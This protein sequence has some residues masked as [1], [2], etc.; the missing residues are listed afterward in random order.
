[1]YVWWIMDKKNSDSK[2]GL[3]HIAAF[4][5]IGLI[6]GVFASL[7]TTVADK[8]EAK[9]QMSA[10]SKYVKQQCVRY[11]EL[12]DEY[13][14]RNLMEVSDKAFAISRTLDFSSA[15]LKNDIGALAETNR[16]NGIFVTA[17]DETSANVIVA[18]YSDGDENESS[19]KSILE[20]YGSVAGDFS[21]SYS[22]RVKKDGY[23][24]DCGI[25]SRS[26]GKGVVL[27]YRRNR[28][29]EVEDERFSVKTLLSGFV[30]STDGVVV[31][32]DGYNVLAANIDGVVG[33]LA[34]DCPVI[35]ELR[36]S[37]SHNELVLVEDDGVY[38]GIKS[39]TKDLFVYTYM[40]NADVFV[41]RSMILPYL[42][43]FY[44]LAVSVIITVRAMTI[45]KKR[46]EQERKD[47]AYRI[48][49]EKLAAEAIRA[50]EAKTDFLR[51]MSH[52]IRT[53]INGI[54]GMVKIGEYYYDDPE[55]QRECR[56]KIWD[57]SGYLLDLVNDI[58][59]MNK[60]TTTEP[61][62]N[63]EYF[64]MSELLND[65]DVFTGVQ[66]KEAGI[67][68]IVEPRA[69]VHDYVYGGKVQ[70][71]RILINLA[72]NAIKY[73][74][75]NG[76]VVVS[77]KETGYKNGIV[78]FEC[79]CADTGIGMDEEFLQKMYEPF[80][81]E[82][83]T[84]GAT[85][86]GVGLG[87]SIVKKLIDRA[88]WSI[89]AESKKGEGTTFTVN[90]SLKA[91]ETREKA[92]PTPVKDEKDRLKGLN[93]LVAED[94]ELNFEIV[95]FVLDVAGAKI[96]SAKDG[97]EAVNIFKE[98]EEGSIDAILMDVM[99][100]VTDGLT[101]TREIRA[102]ERA[103]A[104]IVPIIAMTA[105]AFADDVENARAA[106]MNAHIAKPIDGDKL[107][108]YIQRLVKKTRGGGR[109]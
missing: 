2:I 15:E 33:M 59:D 49:K 109:I 95:E 21:K 48:E 69:I 85:L 23:C 87:L 38:Y 107:V 79:R 75:P 80:E 58:L 36:K 84:E 92:S 4:I 12:S 39:Q 99:M 9:E 91:T 64:V 60:L 62:W 67:S 89:S 70:L 83:Q 17:F 86:E 63:D 19:W 47:E 55:K 10:V 61:V 76:K 20:T 71:K 51:R 26:D 34:K 72:S 108:T 90:I 97:R 54:R 25:V 44:L 82:K 103:D 105:S 81:R 37:D 56:E 73:N 93:I 6:I 1:M 96:I 100:P 41:R 78:S 50:N 42:L 16:L 68:L 66:A 52:D 22:E 7:I 5:L 40:P 104:E 45:R 57:V 29:E 8:K 65:V 13:T 32:T 24:Y 18:F 28:A 74:K 14:T 27:C 102:M 94:N 35:R 31:V 98:S 101:A 106:G 46:E 53:P 11:D 3:V 77:C 43:L 30:Y 88:G